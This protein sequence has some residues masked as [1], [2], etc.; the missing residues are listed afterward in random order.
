M[1]SLSFPSSKDVCILLSFFVSVV[2][3]IAHSH[4]FFQHFKDVAPCLLA[5][6]ASGE[7]F[8]VIFYHVPLQ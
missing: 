2:Y 7:K 6:M 1:S 8:S 5:F 4:P 3:R